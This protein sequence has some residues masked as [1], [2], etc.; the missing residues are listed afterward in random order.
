MN[1]KL[2]LY[3][4]AANVTDAL[5]AAANGYFENDKEAADTIAAV[6]GQFE[7][8]SQSVI[9]WLLNREAMA[10]S[11]ESRIKQAAENLKREK[12]LHDSIRHA[13]S[14][15]MQRTGIQ[16]IESSDGLFKASFRKSTAV[17]VFDEAQI[18][19]EFM[20]EKIS[21]TP[22]KTAIKKAIESGREVAGA[23]LETRQN[24][25]IK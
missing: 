20:R 10:E 14:E 1:H 8:D 25:Q 5:E 13:I 3:Q 6:Q 2:M 24:L 12:A 7:V 19:A 17:A 22:D 11:A 16:K 15:A 9:A 21:Y 18:P 23:K 4:S